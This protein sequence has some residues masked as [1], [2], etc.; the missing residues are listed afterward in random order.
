MT[1][2][3]TTLARFA[4]AALTFVAAGRAQQAG[5]AAIDRPFVDN[6]T[7]QSLPCVGC[8]ISTFVAATSTP[9]HTYTDSSL[10][11]QNPVIVTLDSAGYS[12]SGL[13]IGGQ[14]IKLI[15]TAANGTTLRTTDHIC[16]NQTA[17]RATLAPPTFM[18]ASGFGTF[19]LGCTAA[20]S[21]GQ[22]LALAETWNVPSGAYACDVWFL[23]GGLIRANT[24]ATITLSGVQTC[25]A[26][27]GCFDAATNASATITP[28]GGAMAVIYPQQFGALADGAHDDTAQL[29]AAIAAAKA[30]GIP[31]QLTTGVYL[32]NTATAGVILDITVAGSGSLSLHGAGSG[33]TTIK[34]TT[35]SADLMAATTTVSALP[36]HL[37]GGFTLLGPDSIAGAPC[38]TATGGNGL[39]I[40]GTAVDYHSV[41]ADIKAQGFCGSGKAGIWLDNVENSSLRDSLL[42]LNDIGLK[43]TSAPNAL[44]VDSVQLSY[45]ASFGGNFDSFSSDTFT[46]LTVQSNVKTGLRITGANSNAFI[47]PHF[48]NNNTSATAGLFA[49]DLLGTAGSYVLGNVFTGA[50]FQGAHENVGLT[51]VAT[52]QVVLNKFIGGL[53]SSA[54]NPF[55]ISNGTYTLSTFDGLTSTTKITDPNFAITI[56]NDTVTGQSYYQNSAGT[57]Y[58][59]T[60]RVLTATSSSIGGSA[61]AAGACAFANNTLTGVQAGDV[62]VVAPNNLAVVNLQFYWYAYTF[63]NTVGVGVCATTAGTP[64][65]STYAI[66]VIK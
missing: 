64:A 41:Y 32:A 12:S 49:L 26:T 1:H 31:V 39:R 20:A 22:T 61:L 35:A 48:E 21:A 37:L 36:Q 9:T 47:A 17:F 11:V 13:W 7:G 50:V 60:A 43:L 18:L 28:G 56:L 27:Q 4:L 10:T 57:G 24:G 42:Q 58:L 51:G 38:P 45:N 62:A 19:A 55:V 5:L 66:R 40:S 54:P 53:S 30:S 29:R 44:S 3:K 15:L 46:N 33:L 14:C 23:H 6:A 2:V 63:A 34:T 65:A 16:D 52:G 25:P 8:T 59:Q